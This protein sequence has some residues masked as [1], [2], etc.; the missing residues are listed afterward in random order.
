MKNESSKLPWFWFRNEKGKK[1][2]SVT[3]A[4]ISFFVT[5]LV[6][7][8]SAFESVGSIQF[9]QFDAAACM[10]YFL[11]ALSLYFGRRLTDT[12]YSNLR[13]EDVKN[14]EEQQ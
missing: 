7:L 9:R 12:K 14:T 10:A 1:S 5:T 4:S 3:F 2:V 8:A 6:Y 13:G 11:P